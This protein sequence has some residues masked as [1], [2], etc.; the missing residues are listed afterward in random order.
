MAAH[1]VRRLSTGALLS[2]GSLSTALLG[3]RGPSGLVRGGA[4]LMCMGALGPRLVHAPEVQMLGTMTAVV[5]VEA[6]K[7]GGTES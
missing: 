6:L 4:H 7:R 2:G 3:V 1:V 5:R